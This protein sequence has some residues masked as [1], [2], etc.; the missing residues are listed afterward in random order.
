MRP[1]L[2]SRARRDVAQ[3]Y[4]R[5]IMQFGPAQANRYYDGLIAAVTALDVFPNR[6]LVATT[7][8]SA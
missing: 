4:R 3:I 5:S 2:S 6:V 8:I 7:S 1:R